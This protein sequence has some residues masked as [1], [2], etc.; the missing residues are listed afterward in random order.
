MGHEQPY[1]E[2]ITFNNTTGEILSWDNIVSPVHKE[3]ITEL[4]IDELRNQYNYRHD[5]HLTSAEYKHYLANETG[6]LT[7]KAGRWHWN[8]EGHLEKVATNHEFDIASFYIPN[9]A[10]TD[11][12]L[13]FIYQ[14]YEIDAFAYGTYYATI[15]YSKIRQWLNI[16]I[17]E[18]L[19]VQHQ[20]GRPV[21][22]T[23]AS[24]TYPY[25]ASFYLGDYQKALS[26]MREYESSA[27]SRTDLIKLYHHMAQAYYYCGDYENAAKQ[28]GKSIALMSNT[29]GENCTVDFT[30]QG[31]HS[32]DNIQED[33]Y[34][35][36]FEG[37][38]VAGCE[39]LESLAYLILEKSKRT[40]NDRE[41]LELNDKAVDILNITGL[42][43]VQI[44]E[45]GRAESIISRIEQLNT[46][47]WSKKIALNT[48]LLKLRY[49]NS[50]PHKDIAVVTEYCEELTNSTKEYLKN[51]LRISTEDYRQEVWRTYQGLF[52]TELPLIA[53]ENK[54]YRLSGNAYDAMLF[55]KGYLL[56]A[57]RSIRQTI[58]ESGSKKAKDLFNQFE[59]QRELCERL[60]LD[61]HTVE[62]VLRETD[63]KNNWPILWLNIRIF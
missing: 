45:R 58:L 34:K 51:V 5:T 54:T 15:P 16:D 61:K 63:W 9:P 29:Y 3:G 60:W 52:L 47:F 12:G 46:Y 36:I 10:L 55:G 40:T 23:D 50:N 1:S 20:D 18:F 11:E 24:E 43:Y 39:Q 30:Y 56:S 41:A 28:D 48:L 8:G 31:I 37:Q 42:F 21:L 22:E 38:V 62:Y 59:R 53:H 19:Q 13:L 6:S 17:P 2:Y 26:Q 14:P 4:I 49:E 27:K 7:S 44:G 33:A 57:T 35:L 32:I 25:S